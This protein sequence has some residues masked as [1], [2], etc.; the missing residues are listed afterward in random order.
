MEGFNRQQSLCQ[1]FF[2]RRL[3]I[4]CHR[5]LIYSISTGVKLFVL[6]RNHS[7]SIYAYP[8]LKS[9]CV[10]GLNLCLWRL[11]CFNFSIRFD[12]TLFPVAAYKRH[13]TR[14]F[15]TRI[16]SLRFSQLPFSN[17]LLLIDASRKDVDDDYVNVRE[18]LVNSRILVL[19]LGRFYFIQCHLGLGHGYTESCEIG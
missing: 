14:D 18:L 16:F 1:R 7:W 8:S 19:L 15:W 17:P 13:V 12:C 10:S 3:R 5:V 2:G 6:R 9:C 11:V 4:R